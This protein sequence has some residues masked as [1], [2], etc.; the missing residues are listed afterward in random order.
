MAGAADDVEV[1]KISR[2]ITCSRAAKW[3]GMWK[4]ISSP[5]AVCA[6]RISI[7]GQMI[8]TIFATPRVS[9]ADY[10]LGTP[11]R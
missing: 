6:M 7:T 11:V 2:F 1:P 9:K 4:K 5:F 8:D 3:E 10:C